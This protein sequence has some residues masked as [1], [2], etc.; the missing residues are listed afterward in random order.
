MDEEVV[1]DGQG[2]IDAELLRGDDVRF[3]L[4]GDGPVASELRAERDRR[5]LSAVEFSPPMPVKEIGDRLLACDALLVPLRAHPALDEH[6]G[7]PLIVLH[8][9]NAGGSFER[10]R[11]V[12]LDLH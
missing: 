3:A 6:P 5:H 10:E 8:R 11:T 1:E 4:I 7:A 2:R 12:N 9:A